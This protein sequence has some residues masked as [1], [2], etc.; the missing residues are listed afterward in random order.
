MGVYIFTWEKLKM[1]LNVDEADKKSSDDF[2]KNIIPDMLNDKQRL[3][4]YDFNGYWKDVGTIESL[5]EANMD[6]LEDPMPMDM[7]DKKWRIY[8]RNFGMPPHYIAKGASVSDTLITEGCEVYGHVNHS[9]LFS[10][11]IVEEG[12]KVIDS[13]IMPGS[14]IRR[15]AVVQRTIVAEN[16]TIGAGAIVGESEEQSKK[17]AVIGQGI[18][19]PAG[20]TVPAGAQVDESY[21]F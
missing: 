2:G 16:A 3:F 14:V 17:I 4:A 13:V 12:A 1:Y 9:I 8:A 11:V 5:W 20:V 18:E 15:G 10:G 7:H 21:T 6:L 19:L